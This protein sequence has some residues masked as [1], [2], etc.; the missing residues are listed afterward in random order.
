M[1]GS[2]LV[3]WNMANED[4]YNVLIFT[5]KGAACSVVR[6]FAGKT[7]DEGSGHR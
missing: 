7:L 1:N 3:A 6:R 2:K 4:L 5:T